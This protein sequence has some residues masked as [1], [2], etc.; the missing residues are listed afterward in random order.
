MEYI[1]ENV[2]ERKPIEASYYPDYQGHIEYKK[3]NLTK[4]QW[5]VYI[6]MFILR[7]LSSFLRLALVICLIP[8]IVLGAD[9]INGKVDAEMTMNQI[10][11]LLTMFMALMIYL[12]FI[13]R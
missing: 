4:K 13:K 2:V 9:I 8:L 12:I 5:A 6:G 1:L 7:N 3:M 10:S 11:G